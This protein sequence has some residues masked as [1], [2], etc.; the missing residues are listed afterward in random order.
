MRKPHLSL[1]TGIIRICL[2]AACMG[3]L[4]SFRSHSAVADVTL[5]ASDGSTVYIRRDGYGVPHIQ[6]E[7]ESGVFHG[8]G[9][10]VAQ[11]RMYQLEQYRRVGLGRVSEIL[12]DEYLDVDRWSRT[13]LYTESEREKQFDGLPATVK[14]MLE[15]YCDGINAYLD[16]METDPDR[17]L[18]L[19]FVG[20]EVEPWKVT[21]SLAVLQYMMRQFGQFGGQE[22]ARA[23]ELQTYGREWFEEHRPLNDSR[24][25]TTIPETTGR[26]TQE[27]LAST[28][29]EY[30]GVSIDPG[31]INRM[32]SRNERIEALVRG[33]GIP[34]KFGS[35]AVL[36]GSGKSASGHVMLLGAPQMEITEHNNVSIVNEVELICPTLHVGGMVVAGIPGVLI[37][38]NEYAAWTLTSGFSDNT[39]VYIETTSDSTFSQYRYDGRWVDFE[40]FEEV[41]RMPGD[42][43]P[44]TRYR[45]VHGPVFFHDLANRQAFSARM[46]FWNREVETLG[47]LY[48]IWKSTGVAE[49]AAGVAAIPV[50]FNFFYAGRDQTIRHWH[51]GLYQDRSDGVDPRLPH[52]GD[53]S[54]EWGGLRSFSDLPGVENP[55]QGYL[56]NWNNK[57]AVWWNNGDNIPWAYVR[58]EEYDE[59]S[60]F[61]HQTDRVTVIDQYVGPTTPFSYDNLEDVP[62]QIQSYGTYMQAIE[63]SEEEIRDENILPPGQSGFIDMDGEPSPHYSDQWVLH[64]NWQFKD[65]EFSAPVSKSDPYENLVQPVITTLLNNPNPL[66]STTVISFRLH[67]ERRVGLVIYNILGERV[68]TLVDGLLAPGFHAVVWNAGELPSG[69][70]FYRLTAGSFRKTNKLTIIR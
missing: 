28:A 61:F 54:E 12:G 59:T 11:D 42:T 2:L 26:I 20:L 40:R 13:I 67:E 48:A 30:S 69:V 6:G 46:A 34:R 32:N 52:I 50:S 3:V 10:A 55:A 36:V 18:P 25:P 62:R 45:T 17:Y 35:F 58:N 33:L 43:V 47:A 65:M 19:Q 60:Q 5:T 31:A 64:E 51:V 38:H 22:L 53:G 23:L 57:P 4:P 14:A 24:A 37:G 66:N 68:D 1:L 49:F 56:V 41:I 44:F 63:L 39:D 15:S 21:D 9:F 70:Y 29:C 7:T 8:Q 16:S 27:K